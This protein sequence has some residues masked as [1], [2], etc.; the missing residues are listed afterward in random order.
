MSRHMKHYFLAS[1]TGRGYVDFFDEEIESLD[2]MFVL[3]SVPGIGLTALLNNIASHFQEK[4]DALEFVHDSSEADALSGL[5]LR[6]R[7][8]GIF[9]GTDPHVLEPSAPYVDGEYVN[10]SG[11]IRV[12]DLESSKEEIRRL[13]RQREESYRKFSHAFVEILSMHEGVEEFYS[14]ALDFDAANQLAAATIEKTFGTSMLRTEPD[15]KD[16]FFEANTESKHVDFVEE[17]T[18]D[19]TVRY[20]ITGGPGTG[21][22]VFMTKISEA[23]CERGYDVEHYHCGLDPNS[24]DLIVLP[25]LGVAAFDSTSPHDREPSRDGDEVVNMSDLLTIDPSEKYAAEIA[26]IEAASSKV[27]KTVDKFFE[28][29]KQAEEKMADLYGHAVDVE[30]VKEMEAYIIDRIDREG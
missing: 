26:E 10:I 12:D 18:K 28:K 9:D 23:A 15:V 4:G 6:D 1:Y 24:L 13:Q 17:L 5:I 30:Q 16:R 25:E 19:C 7:G 8:V 21:K 27:G 20:F 2:Y 11:A 29:A 14:G 22:S 3:K